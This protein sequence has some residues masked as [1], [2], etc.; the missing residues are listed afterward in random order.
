[1]IKNYY[2]DKQSK[3]LI[4]NNKN[5]ILVKNDQLIFKNLSQVK[6]QAN[7]VDKPIFLGKYQNTPLFASLVQNMTLDSQEEFMHFRKLLPHL[8]DIQSSIVGK[9]KKKINLSKKKK[10]KKN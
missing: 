5:D 6:S 7:L 9:K 4:F 8:D 1:M 2:Q 3:S 10:K